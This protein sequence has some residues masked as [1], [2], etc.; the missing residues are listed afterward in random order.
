MI[1]FDQLDKV[2]HEKGRLAI[3]TVL[4]ASK[5]M[6]FPDLKEALGM[7]D[8]NLIT[9]ARRLM[10]A[11]YVSEREELAGNRTR[12]IYQLTRPG[13]TAYRGYIDVLEAI[14]KNAKS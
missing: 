9:H 3:M 2:I 6:A 10:E 13:R 12:T 1:D 8:G 14:V 11:G 7:S 4:A 5:E